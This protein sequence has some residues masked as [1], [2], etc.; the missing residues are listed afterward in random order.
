MEVNCKLIDFASARDG[1]RAICYGY[2]AMQQ[3]SRSDVLVARRP[4]SED[5]QLT[6]Y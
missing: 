4:Y 2:D 3:I 6:D 5:L 1:F